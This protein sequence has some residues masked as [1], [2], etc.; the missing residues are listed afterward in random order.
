M[1]PKPGS[2]VFLATAVAIFLGASSVDSADN[3][4]QRKHHADKPVD[5]QAIAN[6]LSNAAEVLRINSDPVLRTIV[7]RVAFS[8]FTVRNLVSATGL[9]IHQVN[10]AINDLK[11]MGLVRYEEAQGRYPT[12]RYATSEAREKMRRLADRY[13][14]TDKKCNVEK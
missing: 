3:F 7:C 12:I 10:R 9:P 2:L 4:R 1:K 14:A 8:P 6:W 5:T 13:C 11:A